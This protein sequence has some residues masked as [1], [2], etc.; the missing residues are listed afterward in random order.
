MVVHGL[1]N[2]PEASPGSGGD[3]GGGGGGF[4]C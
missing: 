3:G 4:H 2:V 1:D